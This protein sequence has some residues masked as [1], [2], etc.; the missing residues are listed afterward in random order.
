MKQ[1]YLY[2]MLSRTDTGMGKIIRLFTRG[3]YN[4]VSLGLDD[5][6][7]S[8]VSFARYARDVS[9]AG[10]YVTE[11]AERLLVSGERLPVRIFRLEITP[12]Q[13]TRLE[14]LFSLA[15]HRET[16]LIY[17]SLGAMLS[18]W[19]IPCPIPGAYTCLEF[20]GAV[21]GTPFPSLQALERHLT[22]YE[23]Y[24]GELGDRVTDNGSRCDS[25]FKRR[26]FFRGVG[27][28]VWHFTRLLGRTLRITHC[29][30]PI[31]VYDAPILSNCQNASP[32]STE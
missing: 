25:F 19:H 31:A 9:L 16:G 3:T 23:I 32:V 17:N 4:H 22:P 14:E 2:V 12:E 30:D 6:L 8:F 20:A 10:G 11:P 24:H 5:D 1:R 21:L 29:H 27:D 13:H 26:G 15:G 18:T 28:T 7:R